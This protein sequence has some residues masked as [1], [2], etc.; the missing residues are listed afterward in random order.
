MH[1]GAAGGGF[2]LN[3][4]EVERRVGP[5]DNGVEVAKALVGTL[6]KCVEVEVEVGLRLAG[7]GHAHDGASGRLVFGESADRFPDGI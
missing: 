4:L 7:E 6:K 1:E 2:L 5:V 3:L